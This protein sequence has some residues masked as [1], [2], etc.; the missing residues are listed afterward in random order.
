M[1]RGFDFADVDGNCKLERGELGIVL[2][3]LR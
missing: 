3:A 1:R 2:A